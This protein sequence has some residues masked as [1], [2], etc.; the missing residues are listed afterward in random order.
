MGA[1]GDGARHLAAL[2]R[3]P[4]PFAREVNVFAR[5]TLSPF[6]NFHRPCLFSTEVTDKRGTGNA[7]ATEM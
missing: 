2:P 7:T 4:K 6:L 5:D 1:C 3:I